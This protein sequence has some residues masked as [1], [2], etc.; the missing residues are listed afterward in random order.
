[1]GASLVLCGHTHR[2]QFF[3]ATIFTRWANGRR[4]FYGR[5]SFGRTEAVI[6]S[7]AGFFQLPMRIGTDSE[8]VEIRLE[9]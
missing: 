7:G 8:V 5:E 3:P 2:G 6:S 4:F 1:M 9:G